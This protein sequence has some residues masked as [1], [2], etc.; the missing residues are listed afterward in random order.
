M[1]PMIK[2]R[3]LLF[4]TFLAVIGLVML[5]TT[6]VACT[7]TTEQPVPL[8]AAPRFGGTASVVQNAPAPDPAPDQ[9]VIANDAIGGTASDLTDWY[10][11]LLGKTYR[12]R[13]IY[14]IDSISVVKGDRT[15]TIAFALVSLKAP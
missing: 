6:V 9:V 4:N 5:A 7:P 8:T 14:R 13:V 2:R 1:R 10:N 3:P 15:T 11:S 12:G